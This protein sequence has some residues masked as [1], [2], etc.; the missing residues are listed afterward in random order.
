MT[1]PNTVIVDFHTKEYS[2]FDVLRIAR[3][4]G[5]GYQAPVTAYLVNVHM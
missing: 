1:E 5:Q 4:V 3:A 2:D